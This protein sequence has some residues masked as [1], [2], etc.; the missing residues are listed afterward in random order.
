MNSFDCTAG[1][2]LKRGRRA[3]LTLIE[4]VAALGLSAMLMAICL[5]VVGRM[6]V[7]GKALFQKKRIQPWQTLLKQQ[8]QRDYVGCRSV[9][10]SANSIRMSG[11]S[12]SDGA[13]FTPSEIEYRIVTN[14]NSNNLYRSVSRLLGTGGNAS[15]KELVCNNVT[16]FRTVTDLDTDVA[17]GVM[18]IEM[19][20]IEQDTPKVKP[21]DSGR[22]RDQSR[23]FNPLPGEADTLKTVL[24]RHGGGV[25]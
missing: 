12:R 25:Q 6:S 17:P 19:E 8:L 15:T 4:L 10:F 18:I 23:L 9:S 11:Y 1:N 14:N 20:L 22:R 16:R 13:R 2:F 3:G 5:T 24:V 21:E 7:S